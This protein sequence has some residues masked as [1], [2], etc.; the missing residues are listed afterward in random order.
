M[1]SPRSLNSK[2]SLNQKN[3]REYSRTYRI[4]HRHCSLHW[5][6]CSPLDSAKI[7]QTQITANSYKWYVVWNTNHLQYIGFPAH[8]RHL[9]FKF[10][11][12]VFD[13]AP[14]TLWNVRL[15]IRLWSINS[16]HCHL[17]LCFVIRFSQLQFK[18]VGH[19]SWARDSKSNSSIGVHF[20]QNLNQNRLPDVKA[21]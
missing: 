20:R 12:C 9:S 15:L 21:Q 14:A 1:G 17:I 10:R 16:K 8:F 7:I 18:F 6:P 3:E 11:K 5:R 2:Q 13:F 4:A 19:S